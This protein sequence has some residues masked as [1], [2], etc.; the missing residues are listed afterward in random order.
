MLAAIALLEICGV[1]PVVLGTAM[2]Q[3]E[4]WRESLSGWEIASVLHSPI[5]R[6]FAR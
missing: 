4:L 1:R 5:I 3:S 2:L 6:T